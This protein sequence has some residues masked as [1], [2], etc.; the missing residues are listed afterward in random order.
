MKDKDIIEK[1]KEVPIEDVISQY[2]EL[3]KC[4]SYYRGRNPL[5]IDKH[6]GS[7]VVYSKNN[8]WIDYADP[9]NMRGDALEFV[10]RMENV[11][12]LEAAEIITRKNF[13]NNISEK[14]KTRQRKKGGEKKDREYLDKV[15][16]AFILSSPAL[17]HEHQEH[18][19]KIRHIR[20]EDLDK[21]FE[22][23]KNEDR[24][25]KIFY[26][27][28]KEMGFSGKLQGIL[29]GVP[30]FYLVRNRCSFT[31]YIGI[32]IIEKDCDDLISGLQIR[33]DQAI[34]GARY[35]LFSS[36]FADTESGYITGGT[37]I[38][39]IPDV[40][41]RENPKGFVITEG[42]FKQILLYRK[43]FSVLSLNGVGNNLPV[44]E[45]I[46]KAKKEGFS[47][48]FIAFDSDCQ[49]KKE[50]KK[51]A[52]KIA[53]IIE[54][55]GMTPFFYC[56]NEE[57]GKGIDDFLLNK[58]RNKG[59]ITLL[60]RSEFDEQKYEDRFLKDSIKYATIK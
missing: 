4:G 33:L 45:F 59:T 22:F 10:M 7:F 50:V 23:P 35:K 19:K 44:S 54:K 40:M 14:A 42:R 28:L 20:E 37:S 46:E 43:G 25:W 32:G 38:G 12:F 47:K 21:F 57:F 60:T 29:K 41:L 1:A 16:R 48:V 55:A 52:L 15:Y 8:Y 9:D 58:D 13:S 56:W 5:R 17:T 30:G 11:S 2:T 24:F 36:G 26:R 39:Q 53:D 34:D 3:K 18:L 31:D 49:T 6:D 27:N 51:A